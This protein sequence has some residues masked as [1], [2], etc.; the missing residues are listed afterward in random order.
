VPIGWPVPL[1]HRA[2]AD[3]AHAVVHTP[4]VAKLTALVLALATSTELATGASVKPAGI[5]ATRTYLRAEHTYEQAIK[6]DGPAD[7]AAVH[8]LIAGV[9]AQCPNVLASAPAN[10]ATQEITREADLEVG[11]ARE[12]PQRRAT[13]AFA[14]TIERLRWSNGKLTYYVRGFAAEARANA[15]LVTPDICVDARAVAASGFH[16]IPASTTRYARDNVC[17]NSKVEVANSPGETGELHE[18][19]LIMLKPYERAGER[20]L[21]PHRPSM[22]ERKQEEQVAYQHLATAESEI[23]HALGLP[24]AEAPPPLAYP[25]TSVCRSHSR[26]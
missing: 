22:R 6:G 23:A 3:E 25:P 1:E 24:K 14:K 12:V 13:I 26:N 11:H 7:E 21:I 16:A 18:I 5:A 10:K 4:S 9:A 20:A 19:I 2:C 17:A 15:E 8:G